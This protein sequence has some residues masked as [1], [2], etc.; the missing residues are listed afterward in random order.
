MTDLSKEALDVLCECEVGQLSPHVMKATM[1]AL[2]D[3]ATVAE[4]KLAAAMEGAVRVKPLD[5]EGN[6]AS[7]PVGLSYCTVWLGDDEWTYCCTEYPYG[8]DS[9]DM[10]EDEETAKAAAQADYKRRI[11]AAIEPDPDARHERDLA[12]ARAALEAATGLVADDYLCDAIRAL[13]PSQIVN[14]VR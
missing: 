1:L 4:A 11:L 13:D 3:R 9:D 10:F 12:V 8:V 14:K 7:T 5:F 2:R 6:S